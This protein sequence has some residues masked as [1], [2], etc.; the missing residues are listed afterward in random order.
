M[1]NLFA[2]LFSCMLVFAG[3]HSY[4]QAFTETNI[5]SFSG[6]YDG[7]LLWM[8]MDNDLDYDLFVVGT[9]ACKVYKNTGGSFAEFAGHNLPQLLYPAIDAADF[10]NDGFVDIVINGN[11]LYATSSVPMTAI[12]LNNGSGIFTL[13]ADDLLPLAEGDIDCADFDRD[14][15]ADILFT[16][17]S[18]D[19]IARSVLYSNN[20]DSS[21]SQVTSVYLKG[22]VDSGSWGD[23]DADGYP[24]I[25]I[26][27]NTVWGGFNDGFTMVYRNKGD[28]TFEAI[29]TQIPQY[30][31]KSAWVD[32]NQDGLQ[33]IFISGQKKE[34]SMIRTEIL[35]NQGNNVFSPL[36]DL[37]FS[38]MGF[39]N[40]QWSDFD[41][42]GDKDL[43]AIGNPGSSVYVNNGAT[44]TKLP[45]APFD[46]G[47]L[48]STADFDSDG[49][50]DLMVGENVAPSFTPI[51]TAYRNETI[52]IN[53][54]PSAPT[55]LTYERVDNTTV[56]LTWSA[57][58]DAE[59]N[60]S[61]LEYAIRLGT[62]PGGSEIIS[63]LSTPAGELRSPYTDFNSSATTLILKNLPDGTYYASVQARDQSYK[64]SLFSADLSFTLTGRPVLPSPP[65][66]VSLLNLSTNYIEVRWTDQSY[67]ED[68]FIIER[69]LNEESN[70][71]EL[72]TLDKN[73]TVYT[74][75]TVD[76]STQY[77]YRLKTT[78]DN[79]ASAYSAAASIIS[80]PKGIFRK[81]EDLVLPATEENNSAAATWVDFDNDNDLDIAIIGSIGKNHFY[82][83]NGDET[84]TRM[85]TGHIATITIQSRT[86]TWGDY[87]NDGDEDVFIPTSSISVLFRNDGG[88]NF[89]D[90]TTAPLN[91]NAN[92]DS[93]SAAWGD[94]DNDGYLD[95]IKMN[96]DAPVSLYHNNQDGTFTKVVAGD[97]VNHTG[98]YSMPSWCDYNSDGWLDMLLVGNSI[99]SALFK[100]TGGSFKKVEAGALTATPVSSGGAS[101]ADYDSDGDFDV[102]IPNYVSQNDI[103][104]E[105]NG[106][107]TFKKTNNLLITGS[108]GTDDC[109]W[110]DYDND[111]YID[112]VKAT[113]NTKVIFHNNGAK[114]FEVITNE[115]SLADGPAYGNLAFGDYNNDGFLDLVTAQYFAD[116]LLLENNGNSNHW[117]SFRLQ[118]TTFNRSAIGASVKIKSGNRWQTDFIQSQSGTRSQNSL[119]VEFGLGAQTV[120]D[121]VV[122]IWPSH[123]RQILTDVTADQ[124]LT[125][126]QPVLPLSPQLKTVAC[127]PDNSVALMW[128][129]LS[130]NET[131]FMVERSV[132]NRHNFKKVTITSADVIT[133][134]DNTSFDGDSVFYRLLA[135]NADGTSWFSNV[136]GTFIPLGRP[137]MTDGENIDHK[138]KVTW[139]DYA[140]SETIYEVERAIAASTPQFTNQG[141]VA[142]NVNTF[143]DELVAEATDYLYRVR[144]NKNSLYSA[145]SDTL[146]ISSNLKT[147]T[148]LGIEWNGEAITLSWSDNSEK[149]L[150]Y[151]VERSIGDNL[152]YEQAGEASVN[153]TSFEHSILFD[154][155]VFYRIK[156][157]AG[158]Y[159][160]EYSNEVSALVT[161]IEDEK[162]TIT[163]WPNP[164]SDFV[165]FKNLTTDVKQVSL[166][167]TNGQ[168]L[169]GSVYKGGE[170]ILLEIKDLPA[171]V[172][173]VTVEKQQRVSNGRLL[174]KR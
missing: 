94:Y 14:G 79:G 156:A 50:Q 19:R 59:T 68:N 106:D 33:D 134:I 39:S 45:D 56:K 12:Y 86:G 75:K 161:G 115:L 46:Q 142:N 41:H 155:V 96:Y 58:S 74:D 28:H 61:T 140:K 27:G 84:F 43:F 141:T 22:V 49:D 107:E 117:V 119:P 3:Q 168:K 133:F 120:I 65:A 48:L 83:N 54:A 69:S 132:S 80:S 5:G 92:T 18:K 152:N 111:G 169:A 38:E 23:Y 62:T 2:L 31:G 66:S 167:N 10:N 99:S 6:I 93:N 122:V 138:I 97:L 47:Q 136:L 100:N 82:F 67:N 51:F 7:D 98:S 35:I 11:T 118:G 109:A 143:T 124:F 29:T 144:A 88:G 163:M 26:S 116:N 130:A 13:A 148:D 9:L 147:P 25:L 146:A 36:A 137:E 105:N 135:V 40:F 52:S 89:T 8:D 127:Q 159:H 103:F 30:S 20:G 71:S 166:S 95:L 171:G 16:G 125:I 101:W 91:E 76:Y 123:G 81:K 87:D 129:D 17:Y 145:Y 55:A 128:D 131:G 73:V 108:I 77:F 63:S 34:V 173:I 53:T 164:A 37:P 57:S 42:D 102:L 60:A 112:I 72:A 64:A 15:D 104:F 121:S 114:D 85:T 153:E 21:F 162:T 139:T 70:Y 78:N 151:S 149:E 4:S 110:G 24:D 44:F 157:I 1:K 160:S 126:T 113:N 172:Y 154:E 90:V 174:I 158:N 165:L 32:V 170:Q 150:A